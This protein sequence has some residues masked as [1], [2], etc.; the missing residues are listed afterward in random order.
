MT[1]PEAANTDD[2][3]QGTRGT[4]ELFSHFGFDANTSLRS[5]LSLTPELD[6]PIQMLKLSAGMRLTT[7]SGTLPS[8]FCSSVVPS[9]EPNVTFISSPED[10]KKPRLFLHDPRNSV[11]K[12]YAGWRSDLFHNRNPSYSSILQTLNSSRLFWVS[13]K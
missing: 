9:E 8:K 1:R 7:S 11:N 5:Q 2:G 10:P 3:R 6:G 13:N 4:A 12:G